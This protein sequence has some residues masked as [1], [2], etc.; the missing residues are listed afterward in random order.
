MAESICEAA[1][2]RQEI[3]PPWVPPYDVL[4][5]RLLKG[6]IIPFLGAGASAFALDQDGGAPPSAKTLSES[7]A[8]G[9]GISIK[10]DGCNH[11]RMDLARIASY[12][13]YF[14]APR[15]SL[16]EV[17]TTE[18]LN[19]RFKPNPLHRFLARAAL[20]KPMLIITTNYDNLLEQAF[21][22]AGAPFE[23]VATPVNDFVYVSK[24]EPIRNKAA[25]ELGTEMAGG[26][27][28]W[29]RRKSLET[30]D[31][32]RV[33]EE[34]LGRESPQTDDFERVSEKDLLFD[35]NQ[36]SVIYKVH[37]TVPLNDAGDRGYLIAEEDY[38]RFLGRM[39]HGG[40][41]TGIRAIITRKKKFGGHNVPANS[42]L[43]LGYSIQ[44]WNL[45]VLLEELKIGREQSDFERHYAIMKQPVQEDEK[46]LGKKNINVYDCDL[47]AFAAEM[48]ARLCQFKRQ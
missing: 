13:Q 30:E 2:Q 33:S 36:R 20:L 42:L 5:G 12:Y 32:E 48:S 31:S 22:E 45:R 1:N 24:T 29:P 44:D 16:D 35:L 6:E 14:V 41:P 23:V 10:Y 4:T 40:V 19:P 27:L 37:G 11:P 15:P 21:K 8:R 17:I 46:L 43:F 34:N 18:I 26:V 28:H 47:G 7:L 9:S 38:I 25:D 3:P 39:E